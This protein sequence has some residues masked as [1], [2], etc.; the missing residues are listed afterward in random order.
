MCGGVHLCI[1]LHASGDL[2][3]HAALHKSAMMLRVVRRL[4]GFVL[5]E[6]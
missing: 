1:K 2:V 4:G 3:V 6:G 5:C